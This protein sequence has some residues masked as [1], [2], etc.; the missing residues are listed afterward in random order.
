MVE[1][2]SQEE[3]L[4]AGPDR[5]VA[6]REQRQRAAQEGD[7]LCVLFEVVGVVEAEGQ[8]GLGHAPPVARALGGLRNASQR[9]EGRLIARE[10]R[11]L[12]ALEPRSSR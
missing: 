9:L 3:A 8:Q 7:H 2:A 12:A 10:R 5:A 1:N 11:G 4:E 6:V